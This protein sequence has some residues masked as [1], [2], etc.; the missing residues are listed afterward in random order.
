MFPAGCIAGTTKG[1]I[2]QLRDS[3]KQF[4]RSEPGS[5]FQ[6]RYHRRSDNSR[7]SRLIT[8]VAGIVMALVGLASMPL[9]LPADGFLIPLGLLLIASE[10]KSVARF[11][12]WAEL[13]AREVAQRAATFWRKSSTLMKV[14]IVAVAL[15]AVATPGYVVF[16]LVSGG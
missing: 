3:W 4:K 15:A 14:L 9:L 5:R 1:M 6:D 13:R 12:D 16:S 10:I 7:L 11:F 2:G 8:L